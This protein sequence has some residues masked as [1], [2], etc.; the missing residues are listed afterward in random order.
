MSKDK[1]EN[2]FEYVSWSKRE[3]DLP[4]R[5]TA[6]SAGYDFHS[7]VDTVIMPGATVRFSLEVKVKLK[8]WTFLM[9]PPRSSLGFKD[10]NYVALTN[11]IGIID[12]DYYNNPKNEGVIELR[13]HNFGEKPFIIN[14]NDRLVQGIFV[15]YD[16][17]DDDDATAER[18]GGLGSTGK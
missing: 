17:T 16:I 18:V 15:K 14:K 9:I 10:D 12:G 8:D 2:K 13:L 1:Q 4:H 7:P 5:S 3:F 11:T 6:K